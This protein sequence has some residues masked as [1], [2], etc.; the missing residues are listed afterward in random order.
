MIF[1]CVVPFKRKRKKIPDL[2]LPPC[3][4]GEFFKKYLEEGGVVCI[5]F[6]SFFLLAVERENEST[7]VLIS[8]LIIR[9]KPKRFDLVRLLLEQKQNVSICSQII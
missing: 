4:Y 3:T 1:S 5:F 8:K 6:L 7:N 9:T 2:S